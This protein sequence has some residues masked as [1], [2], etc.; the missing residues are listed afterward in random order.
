MRQVSIIGKVCH[1]EGPAIG[2]YCEDNHIR[3]CGEQTAFWDNLWHLLPGAG[4]FCLPGFEL[5][6]AAG[7]IV[8][9]MVRGLE[10]VDI[11]E[12]FSLPGAALFEIGIPRGNIGEYEQS[13]KAGKFLLL[14]YGE[15]HDVECACDI[16]RCETQE[17]TVHSA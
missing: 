6:A 14:V 12:R 1:D 9:L 10:N 5:L 15:R 16:L 7:S 3:S 13:I 4:V 17:V 8:S 11:G 2:F